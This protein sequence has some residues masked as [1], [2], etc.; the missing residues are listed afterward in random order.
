MDE[1]SSVPS[2]ELS[3]VQRVSS[4]TWSTSPASV[5]TST[6]NSS[7][8]NG[9]LVTSCSTSGV[10]VVNSSS[11]TTSSSSEELITTS[12]T[13]TSTAEVSGTDEDSTVVV[14]GFS[15]LGASVT[16]I[17]GSPVT[18]GVWLD[19]S[20]VDIIVDWVVTVTS[21]ILLILTSVTWWWGAW[22][23][24]DGIVGWVVPSKWLVS[25]PLRITGAAQHEPK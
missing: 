25:N 15:V 13:S 10:D 9:G 19:I 17:V 16:V 7:S 23:V 18:A 14:A 4:V 21:S 20:G 6:R 11:T 3:L 2:V 8:S 12:G 1:L 22:L 5:V 24:T